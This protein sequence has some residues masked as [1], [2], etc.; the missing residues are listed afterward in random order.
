MTGLDKVFMIAIVISILFCVFKFLEM[1]FIDKEMKPIKNVVRDAV[2]VFVAGFVGVFG[3]LN[4]NGSL[5]DFMKVITNNKTADVTSGT[6]QI[7]TDAPGF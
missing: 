6:T 1:K 4:M 7:F 5:T 2:Y 3:V